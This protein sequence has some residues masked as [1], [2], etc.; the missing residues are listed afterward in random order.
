MVASCM[1]VANVERVLYKQ[2]FP[3]D[4]KKFDKQSNLDPVAGGG[5]RDIR[6][7]HFSDLEAIVKTMFPNAIS[8]ERKRAAGTHVDVQEGTVTWPGAGMTMTARFEPAQDERPTEWRLARVPDIPCF[9]NAT[10]Q[11]TS[12]DPDMIV[13]LQDQAGIVWIVLAL[14]SAVVADPHLGPLVGAAFAG[15][16]NPGHGVVGYVDF[17]A[18]THW[19]Y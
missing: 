16:A 11:G 12:A 4:F 14:R 5:A 8:V 10:Q 15:H 1:G 6:F 9:A 2:L 17:V 18:G 19:A 3:G 7:G 13:L